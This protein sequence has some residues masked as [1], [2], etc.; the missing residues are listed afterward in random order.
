MNVLTS[1]IVMLSLA[2]SGLVAD[3]APAPPELLSAFFGLDDSRQIR[4][5]TL[6][7]CQRQSRGI[8]GDDGMPVIFS[9]EV[10]ASTL[11]PEDFRITTAAGGIALADCVTLRPADEPGELR[12]AL[13]IGEY[14][15]GEDL[16]IRVEIVGDI[17]SLD[18]N[19]NYRG[20]SIS[21][22][23]LDAGPTLIRAEIVAEEDWMLG[24]DDNCPETGVEGMLRAVWV[25]GITKP[26][27]DEI[28]A[29]EMEQ[30][31]VTIRDA[32][33]TLSTVNPIAVGDLNDNDNYHE[34]CLDTSDEPVRLFF[35]AGY[36]TDPN[37]DLN[38]DT[39]IPVTALN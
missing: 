30:Y 7:T 11:D 33:G 16:P 3:E 17:R 13:V 18:G 38:P 24:G 15:S 28:D 9:T 21:V 39:E 31:R 22:I 10:D 14:G 4:V 12:T 19:L 25:G 5:R 29:L 20:A 1:A 23:P 8:P 26:G 36:V 2:T 6:P 34:L 32:S 27:G 37:E 35:P